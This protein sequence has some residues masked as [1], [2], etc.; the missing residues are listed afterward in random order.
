MN[1]IGTATKPIRRSDSASSAATK[2]AAKS[3]TPRDGAIATSF[4]GA[5]GAVTPT[6][7]TR[8]A[9]E[10]RTPLVRAFRDRFGFALGAALLVLTLDLGEEV[11]TGGVYVG[12][13]V[14]AWVE[15]G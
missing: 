6:L 14:E 13:G 4:G 11:R 8:T 3:A 9:R 5:S 10:A 1:V 2:I 7:R 12:A 15:A